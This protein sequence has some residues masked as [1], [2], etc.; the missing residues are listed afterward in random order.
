M[1][2]Y[3]VQHGQAVDKA[4]NPERPLS[5]GGRE[6]VRRVAA[7]LARASVTPQKVLHSG[8]RRARETAEIFCAAL[9]AG[10]AAQAVDGIA[11]NDPVTDFAGGFGGEAAD[12]MVCGHQPFM[13]KLVSHLLT[14]DEQSPCIEFLPGSVACLER[15]G[16]AQWALCWFVRPELCP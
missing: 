14:G 2:L 6:D 12:I 5:D 1:R 9:N 8:K 10:S 16:K 7:A 11:P 4:E 13:G 3:L 15:T